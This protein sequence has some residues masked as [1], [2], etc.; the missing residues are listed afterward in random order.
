MEI[1]EARDPN[2]GLE[3]DPDE[4]ELVLML[5]LICSHS[6]QNAR[7]SIR[8]VLQYLEGDTPLQQ[9]SSSLSLCADGLI[10]V[11]GD[12]FEDCPAFNSSAG[13]LDAVQVSSCVCDS[14]LSSGR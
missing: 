5:G 4:V 2:L 3:F 7:L 6:E 14:L 12:A 10:S 9:L 1:L 11:N 13:G 8:Q